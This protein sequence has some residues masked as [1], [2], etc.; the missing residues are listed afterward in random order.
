MRGREVQIATSL[1]MH[2]AGNSVQPCDQRFQPLLL[3]L[4]LLIHALRSVRQ[5]SDVSSKGRAERIIASVDC[6]SIL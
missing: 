2:R 1:H 3:N 5:P 6:Q 4:V